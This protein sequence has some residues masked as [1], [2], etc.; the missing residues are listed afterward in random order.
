M[1]PS[2]GRIVHYVAR[3][4]THLPAVIVEVQTVRGR[5]ALNVLNHPVHAHELDEVDEVVMDDTF[6]VGTW[7]WPEREA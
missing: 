3:D 4:G 5:C 2:I 7:H 1:K 6:S